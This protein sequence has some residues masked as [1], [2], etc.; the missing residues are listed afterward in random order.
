MI[1]ISL[2]MIV[3]NEEDVIGRC[4]DTVR[5]IVDEIVIVDTGSTDRTKEIVREYTDRVFDFEW[6]ND[7]SAARN[8]AFAQATREYILWMDADDILKPED[9]EKLRILKR[10]LNRNT[11]AVSMLYIL[12]TDDAGN[13]T[14]SSR[15]YR[16]VKREK[17]FRWIGCVH[18]YLAIHGNLIDSD[19]AITHASLRHD[20]NR[21]ITIFEDMIAKGKSFSPRDMYY[22]ANELFD[23]QKRR[24]AI[25]QYTEFI[26]SKQGW[27]ED[28]IRACHRLADLYAHFE[29]KG[30][31]L[32]W[33]FQALRYDAPRSETCCRV[34][35]YFFEQT[36]YVAAIYWYDQAIKCKDHGLLAIRTDTY[37]GW[38]PLLQLCV[39][40][41]KIGEHE[42]ACYYNEQAAKLRPK[43]PI[44]IGNRE[45]FS[46]V[47]KKEI[48][49]SAY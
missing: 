40:Y 39:S 2:C 45:Y 25:E 22:Y 34:G 27:V 47:L 21:N 29:E 41:D 15:R 49:P 42:K 6:I 7:F 30:K 44:V 5:G 23:H 37:T 24:K 16:L 46:N 32:D 31:M 28:N 48:V 26:D 10:S 19:M 17:D 36:N 43:D 3:K 14:G 13:V 12:A 4:L 9:Q 38:V 35:N 1:S 18:E 33:L 8:F 20:S 11:D